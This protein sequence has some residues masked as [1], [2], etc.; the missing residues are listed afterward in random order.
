MISCP[1]PGERALSHVFHA[2]R[3]GFEALEVAD[4]LQKRN[5]WPQAI[6]TA[7]KHSYIARS[8]YL[9]QLERYEILFP[10]HQLPVPK[11]GP[12]TNTE[13]VWEKIQNS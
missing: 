3:H 5:D 6:S 10:K 8:R 1:G 4:A 12:F 11:R 2:C 9:E 13:A 7:Q